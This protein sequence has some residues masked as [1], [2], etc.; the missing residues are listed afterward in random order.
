[1]DLADILYYSLNAG[2]CYIYNMHKPYTDKPPPRTITRG[3]SWTVIR[4]KWQNGKEGIK[5][6]SCF[7]ILFLSPFTTQ[8]F[9][10][11]NVM[12]TIIL[13]PEGELR[14]VQQSSGVIMET[15]KISKNLLTSYHEIWIISYSQIPRIKQ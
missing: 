1:M 10:L 4:Q 5:N 8:S 7:F 11:D 14:N 3:Y 9:R 2:V 12:N 6:D 15:F 13:P